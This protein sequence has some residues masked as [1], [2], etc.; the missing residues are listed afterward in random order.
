MEKYLRKIA[1]HIAG[2]FY[3]LWLIT[4][5]LIGRTFFRLIYGNPEKQAMKAIHKANKLNA[6]TGYTYYVLQAGGKVVIKPKRL[7]KQQLA[8]RGKYYKR[9]TKIHDIEKIALY[10]TKLQPK[11]T[12]LSKN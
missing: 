3:A 8:C 6:A 4:R 1:L 10:I 2:G 11:C 7:I 5:N 9:G 12:S